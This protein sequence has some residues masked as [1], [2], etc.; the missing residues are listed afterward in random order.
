MKLA[1]LRDGTRDG[2]LVVTSTDLSRAANAAAIAPNLQYA[3]DNWDEISPKL[4]ALSDAIRMGTIETFR[5]DPR[6]AAAPLPR[7][8]QFV[9]AGCYPSH[10][11]LT[12][13]A[14]NAPLPPKFHEEPV[15]YQGLSDSFMGP[16]DEIKMQAEWGIDFEA[17][18]VV[19]VDDV[20][21]GVPVELA[22]KHIRL[23]TF[24]ND[25][26]LRNLI[27][28]ELAKGFG[29]LH[30]KPSTTFAPV[31]ATP[32]EFGAAWDGRRL[33]L[34][35]VVTLNGK[36]VGNPSAGVDMAFDFPTCIAYGAKTRRLSAGSIVG[37]GT[38]S[39]RD[40]SKGVC[41]LAEKRMIEILDTGSALT[42]FL[43]YG[44]HVTLSLRDAQNRA[45][46]GLID[47]RVVPFQDASQMAT[48]GAN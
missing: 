5:F 16:C 36:L 6:A 38:I 13:K 19:V 42:P 14:R 18:I 40:R 22:G 45:V 23:I 21:M 1:S 26:S 33:V 7:A 3:L 9:D 47:Q 4:N 37:A 2:R 35:M 10:M 30:G 25:V 11:E 27:P 43:T 44:D 24:I 32:D 41:C 34:Q 28:P 12:R 46:L 48:S 15:M 39:N 29:F 31:A 20:P 17:E 8:Y